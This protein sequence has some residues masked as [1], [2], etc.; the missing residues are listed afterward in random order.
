MENKSHALA[1]GLF[2][3]VLT[4]ALILVGLWFGRDR[5]LRTPYD[6]VTRMSVAGLSNEA[7]VRFRGV[8]VGKVFV[9]IRRA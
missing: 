2:T 6:L 1:A 7:T 8:E 4:I 5:S 3:I 9:L